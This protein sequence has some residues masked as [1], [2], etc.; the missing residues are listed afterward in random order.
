MTQKHLSKSIELENYQVEDNVT[1][2]VDPG[3]T[4][5]IKNLV[6][7]EGVTVHLDNGSL[8]VDSGSAGANF[9]LSGRGTLKI[10]SDFA[11]TGDSC[12]K[13]KP[14]FNRCNIESGIWRIVFG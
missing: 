13:Y 9:T 10:I 8:I 11:I 14:R 5:R 2:T 6:C 3:T 7:G 1:L 12:R 4:T